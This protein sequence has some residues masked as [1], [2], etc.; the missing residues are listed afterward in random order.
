M[1]L[2]RTLVITSFLLLGGCSYA[3]DILATMI[4]GQLTFIV[5]P[6]SRTKPSSCLTMIVVSAQDRQRR[7]EAQPGDDAQPVNT[8]VVWWN[9]VG[10]DCETHFPVTYGVPL[11]GE[12]RS[13]EQADYEVEAKPLTP[14]VIYEVGATAG[15]T[16]YGG[17]RFRL[18][19]DG[20]V[21]NIPRHVLSN[22]R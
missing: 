14:G 11:A 17:G 4:D 7:M 8:G 10:Y 5:D 2:I 6:S 13:P 9:R 18:T 19:G 1:L 21:E 16:G 12:P 20:R 3:Y 22:D 15:A